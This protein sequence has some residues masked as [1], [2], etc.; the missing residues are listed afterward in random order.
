MLILPDCWE[1]GSGN[2]GTGSG[3]KESRKRETGKQETGNRKSGNGE[4]GTGSGESKI[5]IRYTE[6]FLATDFQFF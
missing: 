1:T 6:S 5:A 4:P 2:R 3:K